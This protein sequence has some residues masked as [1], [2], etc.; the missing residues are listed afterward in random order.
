MSGVIPPLLH[1]VFFHI[2]FWQSSSNPFTP[3]GA[4]DIHAELQAVWSP[5]IALT[6]FHDLVLLISSSVVLHH[7]LFGLPLLLFP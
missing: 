6:S 1:I 2:F 4:Q 3:C 5:A 7:V